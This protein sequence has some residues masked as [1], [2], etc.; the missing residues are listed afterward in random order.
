MDMRCWV[1]RAVVAN[2]VQVIWLGPHIVQKQVGKDTWRINLGGHVRVCHRSQLKEYHGTPVGAAWPLHYTRTLDN[3]EETLGHDE[4]DVRET[5]RHRRRGNV[6]EFPIWWAG[7]SRDDASWEPA[8][9][10]LPRY[11]LLWADY[12][13]KHKIN[14]NVLE[15]L[16]AGNGGNAGNGGKQ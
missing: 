3:D 11:N 5:L 7:S 9:S 1:R 2:K 6:V 13:R 14:L 15:H 8:A 12:C 16:H 4:W 10:F